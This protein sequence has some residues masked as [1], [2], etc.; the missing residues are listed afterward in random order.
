[1]ITIFCLVHGEPT[2]NTFS[3]DI[4][5]SKTISTFKKLI[6]KEKENDFH[7][8]DADKLVLWKVNIPV[9][10][11]SVLENLVLKNNEEEGVQELLL[12][13]KIS[14]I[15]PDDP[16]EEHIHVIVERPSC[17]GK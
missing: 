4:D 15:F 14:K 2:T 11:T 13:T 7:D 10:D 1:M 6:K 5:E 3:V 16:T 8:I 12:V 9:N 17:A